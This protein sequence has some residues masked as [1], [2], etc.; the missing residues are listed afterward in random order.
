M[1]NAKEGDG[2]GVL[3][4]CGWIN[5]KTLYVLVSGVQITF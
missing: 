4:L 5:Y 1:D 3:N 2:C